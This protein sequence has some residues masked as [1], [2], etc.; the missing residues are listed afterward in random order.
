[1]ET[2]LLATLMYSPALN[3][4][5]KLSFKCHNRKVVVEVIKLHSAE[6]AGASKNSLNLQ[7]RRQHPE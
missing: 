6:S 7:F 1:M 3:E 2:L 4:A 5:E